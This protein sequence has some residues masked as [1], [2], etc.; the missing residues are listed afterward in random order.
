MTSDKG[1]T[2]NR[3][4]WTMSRFLYEYAI[5]YYRLKKKGVQFS[6][7]H[8]WNTYL[9]YVTFPVRND[10]SNRHWIDVFCI[11]GI[12]LKSIRYIFDHYFSLSNKRCSGLS[13]II[14]LFL[15]KAIS[16]RASQVSGEIDKDISY[17]KSTE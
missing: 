12:N 10:W 11:E 5:F 6:Q 9:E 2:T 13:F 1:G 16:K 3:T 14:H 17:L 4:P 15:R 7:K 8:I